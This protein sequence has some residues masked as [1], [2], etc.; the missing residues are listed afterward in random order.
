LR[1]ESADNSH[2]VHAESQSQSICKV[3]FFTWRNAFWKGAS[4]KFFQAYISVYL[5]SYLHMMTSSL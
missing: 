1:H 4:A 5:Q 3:C 2:I